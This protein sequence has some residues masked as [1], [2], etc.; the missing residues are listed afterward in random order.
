[1]NDLKYFTF[2][3][4]FLY[5]CQE[6]SKD[7]SKMKNYDG[8][9]IEVTNV[10]TLY[11]D[12]A[13]VRVKMNAPLQLEFH[14]G[15]RDFPK[16]VKMNFFNEKGE[17]SAQ[18]TANKGKFNKAQN[19]YTA[20]GNVEVKNLLEKKKLTTEELNWSVDKKQIYTDKFVTIETDKEIL[21]GTGLEATQDFS[22]YKILKP[23]GIFMVDQK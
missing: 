11:S 6:P 5:G 23:S 16:G 21:K 15:D 9:D 8:P 17:N 7:I 13:S 14:N 20:I 1:M 3:L 18:L 19:L 4:I 12:S 2:F 10:E 22:H